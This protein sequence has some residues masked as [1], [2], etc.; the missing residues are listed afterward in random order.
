MEAAE[1]DF[2][3]YIRE[4]KEAKDESKKPNR[5]AHESDKALTDFLSGMKRIRFSVESAVR[6]FVSYKFGELLRHGVRVSPKQF[7][8]VYDI[9]SNCAHTLDIPVPKL[10]LQSS[11]TAAAY[12]LGTNTDSLVVLSSELVDFFS[13]EELHFVIG[14]ECGHIHNSHVTYGTLMIVLNQLPTLVQIAL[15]PLR[16]GLLSWRRK[17]EI[18]ADRA[19]LI[20]CRDSDVAIKALARLSLG[21]DKLDGEYDID[22]LLKQ[23]EELKNSGFIA[24][25]PE[26]WYTHPHIG[27]RIQALQLFADSEIYHEIAGLER[28]DRSLLKNGELDQKTSEIV[29]IL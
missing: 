18:T 28:P 1:I 4:K 22:I 15:E 14:H 26:Y 20:C 27:R 11:P 16:L 2:K 23:T 7:P 19:G 25:L 3:K 29:K 10:F 24:K 21:S 8:K 6:G 5:Y 12:T 17:T 9:I 13:E